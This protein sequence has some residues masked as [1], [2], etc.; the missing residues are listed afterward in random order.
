MQ[1]MSSGMSSYSEDKCDMLR[2]LAEWGLDL[3]YE[4]RLLRKTGK[5]V[6]RVW[7]GLR[8]SRHRDTDLHRRLRKQTSTKHDIRVPDDLTARRVA[9]RC[10]WTDHAFE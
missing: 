4:P 10:R 8:F 9:L 2:N 5:S 6:L 3:S 1:S 7:L